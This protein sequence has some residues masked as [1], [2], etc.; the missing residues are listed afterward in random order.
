V[1]PYLEKNPSHKERAGGVSQGVSPEFK[2]Q[3]EKQHINKIKIKIIFY[4]LQYLCVT[5]LSPVLVRHKGNRIC[6]MSGRKEYRISNAN[7]QMIYT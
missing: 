1:R 5:S 6:L 7:A 2:A 3:Y 4:L